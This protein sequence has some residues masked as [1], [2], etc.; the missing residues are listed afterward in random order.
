MEPEQ[1]PDPDGDPAV[2]NG[3]VSGI[4]HDAGQAADEFG[5]SQVTAVLDEVT[6]RIMQLQTTPTLTLS[7]D[8][9]RT[10][11]IAAHRVAN[12]VEAAVL[13]LVRALDDR[14]EAMPTCAPGKVAATFLVHALRIDPGTAARD[15]A[16]ARA[17]DPDGAG[18]GVGGDSDGAGLGGA[19]SGLPGVG[20]ALAEG[21]I[22]RRHVE[23][24][25]GCLGR[26]D[27]DVLTHVDP[28]G[29]SGIQRVDD[30]LAEQARKHA[31]HMFRRL[32]T[33]LEEALNPDKGFD[34][35]AHQ[36]RYLHLGTDAMTG[37]LI[38]R[39]AL[40]PADGLIVRN[41]IHAL[42]EPTKPSK[43]TETDA[44]ACSGGQVQGE[45]PLGD[46][47][48]AAQRRADAL[49]HLARLALHRG[50]D[51]DEGTDEGTDEGPPADAA[52]RND[53]ATPTDTATS[54]SD[55]TGNDSSCNSGSD[56][57]DNGSGSG[58]SDDAGEDGSGA[59]SS[60]GPA[61]T[62]QSSPPTTGRPPSPPPSKG[63]H[64]SLIATLD[65]LTAALTPKPT[66]GAGLGS[67]LGPGGGPLPRHVLAQMLCTA[68]ISPTILDGNGAVLAQGRAQR[69]AT[70]AQRRAVFARDRGCVIPG[71]DAPPDWCEVHHI[72]PW[73]DGGLTDVDKMA[74]ACGRH[75]TGFHAGIWTI[76]MINGVPW[77]IPPVW[78]DALQRPRRNTIHDDE[79]AAHHLAQ[80]LAEQLELD[81][82]A[83]PGLP[84]GLERPEDP[85]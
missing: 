37:M 7:D 80:H 60:A 29:I 8:E 10:A 4:P 54:P 48:T 46:P 34:P 65:Q 55:D 32:C 17:L 72:T 47:R 81:L 18:V 66:P 62:R 22:S 84:L 49:T 6:T 35:K 57:S 74:A 78:L 70:P 30:F 44:D 15:V 67:D 41:V 61:T 73:A 40:S 23:H 24:A 20:A 58:V 1:T 11:V 38:G 68:L 26:I 51:P 36:K 27:A 42:S 5:A 75:H 76:T 79:R 39:F 12:Q 21:D 3:D 28:D 9:L 64:I 50:T 82:D 31:P 83:A 52:G 63:V 14:P 33:Q 2:G 59:T 53:T 19:V 56:S 45:L 13:H 43:T 16:A 25:V 85:P 71:C 69:L 77:V